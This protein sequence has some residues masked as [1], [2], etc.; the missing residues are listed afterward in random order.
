[1]I[2]IKSL[3][4][5]VKPV[6]KIIG[7]GLLAIAVVVVAFSFIGEFFNSMSRGEK[8]QSGGYSNVPMSSPAPSSYYSDYDSYDY[9]SEP[10]MVF[11]EAMDISSKLSTRNAATPASDP[12][13]QNLSSTGDD[14]EEFEMTQYNAAIETRQVDQTCA[15]IGGLKTRKDVIFENARNWRKGCDYS[16]KVERDAADQ[17]LAFLQAFNPKEL[18]GHTYTVQ[19]QVEDFTGRIDI[20]RQKLASIDETLEKAVAAYDEVAVVATQTENAET[21]AK[22]INSKI[23][24]IEQLTQKRISINSQL[25]EIQRSKSQQLDRLDYTYFSVKVSD[26]AMVDLQGLKDSWS[27]AARNFVREINATVQNISVN[28]LLLIA[29][30]FQYIIYGLILL[31]AAK[32]VW[33]IGKN[34]WQK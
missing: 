33:K 23:N 8:Y 12:Y 2:S 34:I 15:A 26:N 17:M 30:L 18:S 9:E 16:F 22:V 11:E 5:K 21:L 31:L 32:F 6:L 14:A 28:L 4:P 25:E 29:V 13:R 20:L 19:A 7:L 1:M 27:S 10:G 3:G 24:T